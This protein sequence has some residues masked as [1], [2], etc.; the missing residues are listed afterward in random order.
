MTVLFIT[1]EKRHPEPLIPL[2]LFKNQAFLLSNLTVFI[3]G[4]GMFGSLQFLGIFVQT[5]LGKSATASGLIST[6]QSIGLL[7]TSTIGGQIISRTGRYRYLTLLGS[8]FVMLAMFFLMQLSLDT[9][10]WQISMYMVVLGLGFGLMMPTMSMMAQNAVAHQYIGV[11][12]SVN[13]FSRQIGSVLGV[14]VLGALMAN[15]FHSTFDAELSN[16]A[17]TELTAQQIETL[18]DPTVRLNESV[19]ARVESEVLALPGG[20]ALMEQI[21]HA[22]REGVAV[23]IRHIYLTAFISSIIGML[24]VLI[25]REIPLRRTFGPAT[26][27]PPAP[28]AGGPPGSDGMPA[29]PADPLRG[30]AGPSTD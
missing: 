22:Q 23:G 28:A 12:T 27:P 13:Q 3:L 24:L 16:Q 9:K 18:D 26:A 5:A 30:G 7:L 10:S 19:F 4:M 25:M 11:A 6:P 21:S 17:R 14:A 20:A 8:V 2:Y 1:Q 29:A 15:S